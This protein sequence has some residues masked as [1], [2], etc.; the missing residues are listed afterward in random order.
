MYGFSYPNTLIAYFTQFSRMRKSRIEHILHC[1]HLP[2]VRLQ[3]SKEIV[4]AGSPWTYI[5]IQYAIRLKSLMGYR[6]CVCSGIRAELSEIH[7]MP[8]NLIATAVAANAFNR[9]IE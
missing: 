7:T 1:I 3:S 5:T 8:N 2:Y 4:M 9:L 6:V